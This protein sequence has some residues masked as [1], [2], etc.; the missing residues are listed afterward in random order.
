M[1]EEENS[2]L[3]MGSERAGQERTWKKEGD[4]QMNI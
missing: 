4:K 1:G 3:Q 2:Y